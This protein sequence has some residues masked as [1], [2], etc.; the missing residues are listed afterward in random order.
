MKLVCQNCGTKYKAKDEEVPNQVFT[1]R[2][3]KCGTVVEVD[4]LVDN[5]NVPVEESTAS[6]VNP[7]LSLEDGFIESFCGSGADG[8]YP[9]L[10][11][12]IKPPEELIESEGSSFQW[13]VPVDDLPWFILTNDE[14]VGPMDARKL[15]S[16]YEGGQYDEDALVWK[17]G[18]PDWVSLNN[19]KELIG[20]AAVLS[21]LKHV[22]ASRIRKTGRP[23]QTEVIASKPTNNRIFEQ[24]N[25]PTT[26]SEE[27]PVTVQADPL[28]VHKPKQV[29]TPL[30]DA[31]E[32][33]GN[34]H[35]LTE[36]GEEKMVQA[37]ELMQEIYTARDCDDA[38]AFTLS[39]AQQ[40]I[41]CEA[42]SCILIDPDTEE[43]Y[44]VATEGPVVQSLQDKRPSPAEGIIGHA[45]R[46]GQV[47]NVSNPKED[48]R[49][50]PQ[51]DAKSEFVTRNVL[52]APIHYK[53]QPMGTIE[54]LNSARNEGFVQDEAEVLSYIGTV[55][56]EFVNVSLPE[57][58]VFGNGKSVMGRALK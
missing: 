33:S 15:S 13:S 36:E 5:S 41:K 20:L 54:L 53:G 16:E 27:T 1:F 34:Q 48:P 14:T 57:H 55:L 35:A 58:E 56:A 12:S 8:G 9:R 32:E 4:N 50:D 18:M 44:M 30:E 45:A 43:M 22:R 51:F 26:K 17:E 49:F 2:C 37:F 11:V 47:V 29:T 39:R 19:C 21:N 23:G 24:A 38:A 42:G 3:H 7:N 25:K 6:V 10:F 46:T 28:E 31:N 52:C 40:I